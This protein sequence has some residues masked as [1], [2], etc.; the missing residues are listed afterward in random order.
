MAQI[1]LTDW[2]GGGGR[3]LVIT[4][5]RSRITVDPRVPSM[6]GRSTSGFHRPGRQGEHQA[7]TAVRCGIARLWRTQVFNPSD[8]LSPI[9]GS[10]RVTSDTL[11]NEGPNNDQPDPCVEGARRPRPCTMCYT[12]RC[13]HMT[14]TGSATNHKIFPETLRASS[15]A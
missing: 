1:F 7:R 8:R 12:Q 6:P 15:V 5:G 9:K 10:G 4:H 13:N 3:V 11:G 14:L 2:G